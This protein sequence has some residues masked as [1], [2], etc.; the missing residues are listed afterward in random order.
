[1]IA[2]WRSG[3]A[4]QPSDHYWT[5]LLSTA[6]LTAVDLMPVVAFSVATTLVGRLLYGPLGPLTDYLWAYQEAVVSGWVFLILLQRAFA[7][8]A[9][10]LRIASVDDEGAAA[11]VRLG[12]RLVIVG[13]GGWLIAGL[14]PPLGLGA[15]PMMLM[16]AVTGMVV[17]LVLVVAVLRNRAAIESAVLAVLPAIQPEAGPPWQRSVAS[18]VPFAALSY[19]V[20]AGSYWLLRWLEAGELHLLGPTSTGLVLL[21]LPLADRFGREIARVMTGRATPRALRYR[22]AFT[23]VW[24]AFLA[25]TAIAVITRLWGFNFFELAHGPDAPAWGAPALNVVWAI[26][27]AWSAWQF[28]RAA[29]WNEMR[30]GDG[31]D[32]DEA[33]AVGHASRLDTLVPLFRVALGLVTL[34]TLALYALSQADVNI[35]PLLASAGIVGIALGFGAQALVRD[36]LSGIFFLMD[37]AFRVGEYIEIEGDIRGEVEAISLRSLQLRHHLGPVLTIPFGELR[38]VANHNRDWVICKMNFRLEPDTDPKQVKKLVKAV[39]AEFLADPEHGPKFLESLKS[40]GV[41]M[42]DDDSALVFRVKFKCKPRQQFV[43][44]REIYHRLR[45]VFEENGVHLAR[46]KVEVVTSGGDAGPIAL[47]GEVLEERPA[48]RSG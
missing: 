37:D 10:R 3:I 13:V 1:L 35:A 43:L 42:I 32:E 31:A 26:V 44:R 20:F 19:V 36:I 47:P 21:L 4:R 9:P 45:E 15:A 22:A 24:R 12:R 46:R 17:T 40:Q 48:L 34:M 27:I 5:Q 41:Y 11:V 7:P 38:S 14:A 39:G 28:V 16:V 2:P 30:H 33:Q 18:A 25:G 29:L 23:R 8:D 6:V